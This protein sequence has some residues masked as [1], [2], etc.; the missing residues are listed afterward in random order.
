MH[1]HHVYSCTGASVY[2]ECI[3]I[4]KYSFMYSFC[5]SRLFSGAVCLLLA[6]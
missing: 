4:H 1:G 3:V 2:K 6:V 5:V